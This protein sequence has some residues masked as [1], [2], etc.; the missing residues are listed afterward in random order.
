MDRRSFHQEG[1]RRRCR[2]RGCHGA[3]R[4]GNRP[5][6]PEDHR[7]A[8]RRRSRRRSIRFS[9]RRRRWRTSFA[10]RPTAISTSM[11]SR[12][13]RSCPAPQAADAV[14]AGTVEMC[15]TACYYFWGKDPTFALATA[16][17]FS[18]NVRQM[19]AWLYYGGGN[20]LLN[21][22][23]ATQN[24]YGL[25]GGK[26]RRADG[27]LVPQGDQH[28]RRPQ[29]AQDAPR[30]LRRQGARKGRRRAAAALPAA[31]STRR[32]K[33]ARSTPASGS[34]PMTTRSSASTRS[35]NTTTIPASGRAGR[36]FTRWSTS[37]S[38]TSCRRAIRRHLKSACEAAN[39][40]MMASY[41]HKNPTALR[42]LVANGAQL[43]PFSQ[44]I[45][46]A[47]FEAAN[48]TYAEIYAVNA[49]FK[50]IMRARR[51]SARTPICGRRS[52]NT[53]TTRS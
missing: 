36:R 2:R 27:R 3:R 52:R 17:P 19:N 48:A 6:Q 38:G 35:R 13:A 7:G 10:T 1:Q 32:W 49:T 50:K 4:T 24:L 8:A 29:G 28:G 33:R 44:E 9:A 42:S 15:H 23:F 20:D 18:L 40:D 31:K 34:D 37:P 39:C 43:R 25:A 51:P 16:V 45:L 41:D 21:E 53:P 47:C 22:F 14:S 5:V 11:S 26:H 12:P 46:A 30:R